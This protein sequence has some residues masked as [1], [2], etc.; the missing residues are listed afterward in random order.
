MFEAKIDGLESGP[1]PPSELREMAA[2]GMLLPTSFVRKVGS[3]TWSEA[4]K[5]QGLRFKPVTPSAPPSLEAQETP[6]EESR[7]DKI[8]G[9][10]NE[11]ESF[12]KTCIALSMAIRVINWI[13]FVIASLMF[14]VSSVQAGS[15]VLLILSL[16]SVAIAGLLACFV[17]EL[18][19]LGI[20]FMRLVVHSLYFST[21]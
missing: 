11:P 9:S 4:S 2:I 20:R 18:Q 19:V 13:A 6:S 8:T 12:I 10:R 16:I 15:E 14:V 17:I 3:R 5:L 1:H 7:Y 21:N